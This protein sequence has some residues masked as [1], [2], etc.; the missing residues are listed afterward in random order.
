MRLTHLDTYS[1]KEEK[2]VIIKILGA[3]C[4]DCYKLIENTKKALKEMEIEAEIIHI[5]K[6]AEIVAYGVM[7]TPSLVI[8]DEVVSIGKV[9]KPKDIVKLLRKR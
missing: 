1:F 2:K 6:L 4:K 8:D 5:E 9:L 7:Q 3:G